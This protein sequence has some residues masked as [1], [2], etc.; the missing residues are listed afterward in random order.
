MV[1]RQWGL[2]R[3]MVDYRR[4][5]LRSWYVGHW[6]ISPWII[7]GGRGIID[8]H[9]EFASDDRHNGL[10]IKADQVGLLDWNMIRDII[11]QRPVFLGDDLP[12]RLLAWWL[13]NFKILPVYRPDVCQTDS[14]SPGMGIVW[15]YTCMCTTTMCILTCVLHVQSHRRSITICGSNKNP[16][17]AKLC[18]Y[19]ILAC[20]LHVLSHRQSKTM[21]LK[22]QEPFSGEAV[23]IQ[24]LSEDQ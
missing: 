6:G 3:T 7:E 23:F 10:V 16:S 13:L 12:E 15:V 1:R 17:W 20:V 24:V 18:V 9:Q 4:A 22:Q 14:K 8:W 5:D 11:G 21:L 2:S 19:D